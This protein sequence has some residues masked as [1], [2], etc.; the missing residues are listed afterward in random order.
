MLERVSDVPSLLLGGL[1][2]GVFSLAGLLGDFLGLVGLGEIAFLASLFGALGGS[3]SGFLGL[4]GNGL[5]GLLSRLPYI[6]YNEN[7]KER[8]TK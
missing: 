1:L 4:G 8:D 5:G 2:G 3:L 6:V 7:K